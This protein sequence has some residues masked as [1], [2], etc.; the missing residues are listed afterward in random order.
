MTER[1]T[2]LDYETLVALREHHPAWRLVASQHAPLTAELFWRVFVA[3]NRREI[4]Q[5]ELVEALEDQLF[6]LRERLGPAAFSRSSLAYLEDW[7]APE[8]GWL[9]KFYLAESDEPHYD[10]TPAAEKA[11]RWLSTLAARQFV[12]TESR[13]LTLFEL[14]RQMSEGSQADPEIR[15]AQFQRRRAEIDAEI[16]QIEAGNLPLLD[17][18]ALRDRFQQFTQ[19]ANELL[20]D[21]REVEQNFRQLGET[22][23]PRS[24]ASVTPS[25]SRTRAATSPPSGTSQAAMRSRT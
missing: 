20:S 11:V 25:P 13:L 3:P 9:R 23:W 18:V 6:E 19:T 21:F 7:A 17:D 1:A 15:I 22:C 24:S 10:L 2:G 8:R 12:G 4:A 14:L 16:A 5:P